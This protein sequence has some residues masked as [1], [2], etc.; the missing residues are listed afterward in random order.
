MPPAQALAW[1]GDAIRLWKR[2]PFTFS[3]IAVVVLVLSIALEPVPFAGI[4]AANVVAPLIACGFFYASLAADRDSKPRLV[5]MFAAFVAPLRAQFAVVASALAITAVE[6]LVAWQL[7]GVNLLLPLHDA[8]ALS[9]SAV[10]AIYA[11]GVAASLPLTFV[12]MAALFDGEPPGAAFA[13]S[14]R[15]FALNVRPLISL[16]ID[17]YALLMTGIVTYGVGLVLGLPWIAAASYAAWKDVYA[18]PAGG[19]G[20]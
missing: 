20:P 4:V 15:A 9:G 5:H 8:G 6:G 12:P 11:A 13:T 7:A 3:A 18:V 2:A 14:L 10:M 17:S 16:G 19:Q 1:F